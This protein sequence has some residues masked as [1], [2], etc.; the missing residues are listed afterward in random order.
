VTSIQITIKAG[1]KRI[2]LWEGL[3]YSRYAEGGGFA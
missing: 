2:V 1:I 3:S